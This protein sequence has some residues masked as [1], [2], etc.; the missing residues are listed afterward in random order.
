MLLAW[1][2][3]VHLLAACANDS[4][5][6]LGRVEYFDSAPLIDAPTVVEV[7]AAATVSVMTYGGGCILF[8]RTE[9][10][11][12]GADVLVRPLDRRL[13]PGKNEAC[14][15]E[16]RLI[17]HSVALSFETPG[18]KTVRIEG[19]RVKFNIDEE[20]SIPLSIMVE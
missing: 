12:S 16:L 10:D 4:V 1:G 2:A 14:T 15:Q 3:C 17:A 13:I 18:L 9:V 19:R 5:V 8:E 11:D 7:G 20:I 6:E